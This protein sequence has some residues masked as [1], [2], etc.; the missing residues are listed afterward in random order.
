MVSLVSQPVDDKPKSLLTGYYH[1][2]PH[3]RERGAPATFTL[4]R[5]NAVESMVGD[6]RSC[7][8]I[9]NYSI[10]LGVSKKQVWFQANY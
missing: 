9:P 6:G 3:S 2:F 7:P 4:E 1:P 5:A 10:M 8:I